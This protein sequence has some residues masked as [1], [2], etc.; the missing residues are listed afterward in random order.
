LW[1]IEGHLVLTTSTPCSLPCLGFR[2]V[3]ALWESPWGCNLS[4][5]T[6]TPLVFCFVCL[7]CVDLNCLQF[8]KHLFFLYK[9]WTP[10]RIFLKGIE[11]SQP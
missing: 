8:H 10:W 2:P 5:F 11:A 3:Q 6:R 4:Y 7:R 9:P 1:M